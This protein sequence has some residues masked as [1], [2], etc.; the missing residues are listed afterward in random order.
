MKLQKK[1][2]VDLVLADYNP[3]KISDEALAG[4]T[5]SLKTFGCV[6]PI[7]W[8]K[9][10]GRVVGGHQRI[11]AMQSLG[12]DE[13]EVIVVD[14]DETKE[15]AL[16]VTL[17]NAKVQGEWDTEKLEK[18]IGELRID[19][20]EFGLLQLDYLFPEMPE[21]INNDDLETSSLDHQ[22]GANSRGFRLGDLMAYITDE[23]LIAKMQL[24]TDR[25]IRKDETQ[26][27]LNII[28]ENIVAFILENEA[29]F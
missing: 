21:I 27:A 23:K 13:C 11:K 2:I 19:L 8:N 16:N 3:R 15:K 22:Y 29:R 17:N 4:L 9:Q 7:I 10:T 26:K 6:E 12:Q 18:I 14:L 5:E 24:F 28:A 25:I 1:K 20:S